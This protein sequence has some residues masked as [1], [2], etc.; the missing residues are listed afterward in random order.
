MKSFIWT[1][2]PA[3]DSG[4][5]VV[6]FWQN[7]VH[8]YWL[9]V[10]RTKDAQKKCFV[11]LLASYDQCWPGHKFPTQMKTMTNLFQ[12]TFSHVV[13]YISDCAVYKPDQFSTVV[14]ID[15]DSLIRASSSAHSL[16]RT[17]GK[18]YQDPSTQRPPLWHS[19]TRW[20]RVQT[21]RIRQHSIMEIDHEIFSTVI[22]S[23]PLIQE[24]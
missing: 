1:F 6:S 21:R 10:Y 17:I 14:G 8:K 12:E 15:M 24:G 16:N 13:W 19:W 23:L 9:T 18:L 3:A 5:V 20:L 7:C 2:C 22:L 11:K 4:R